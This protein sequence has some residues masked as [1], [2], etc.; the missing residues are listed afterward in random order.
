VALNLT[1]H[2]AY[3]LDI[4]S[5]VVSLTALWSLAQ[6]PWAHRT[7]GGLLVGYGAVLV[8]FNTVEWITALLRVRNFEIRVVHDVALQVIALGVLAWITRRAGRPQGRRYA[9]V[10]L[11][12]AGIATVVGHHDI[13]FTRSV[14]ALTV[15]LLSL[16]TFFLHCAACDRRD[17]PSWRTT[18]VC[19][20]LSFMV[21][22][23]GQIAH[24]NF[25]HLVLSRGALP[26][27]VLYFIV[28][29]LPE[30]ISSAY[31]IVASRKPVHE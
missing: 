23:P 25:L 5:S 18:S 13:G 28:N 20:L 21:Q 9:L 15:F 24:A 16:M 26:L 17:D 3:A 8:G 30:V 12:V 29:G 14:L 19:V 10:Y 2:P 11:I 27:L 1:W 6:R 31:L 4:V 22:F 7:L